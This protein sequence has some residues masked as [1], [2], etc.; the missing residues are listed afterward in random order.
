MLV[1]MSTQTINQ[2]IP[3]IAQPIDKDIEEMAK[4]GVHLGHSKAKFHP[5]MAPYLFGIRNSI[6]LIDL[7]KT[8]ERLALACDFLKRI[9]AKKGLILLVGTRPA[10][11]KLIQEIG[12]KTGMPYFTERW[13]GGTLTNYKVVSKRVEYLE[14]LEHEQK[15]GEL[16]KYTKKERLKKG[17]EIERLSRFF[18]GVRTLKRMP[19]AVFVVDITFDPIAV[20]EA[21]RMKIPVVA[22]VD[23][24]SDARLVDWPIPANDDALP[25]LKYLCGEILESIE[26][27]IREARISPEE[28]RQ[29]PQAP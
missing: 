6:S 25:S 26:E 3:G 28:E 12:E 22:F 23:T 2:D 21:K 16:E 13:I 4:A 9:A 27:G 11:R 15:T 10:A 1:F 7:L 29:T 20:R 19:D 5:S 8:K 17:E 14:R 24:N 18:G